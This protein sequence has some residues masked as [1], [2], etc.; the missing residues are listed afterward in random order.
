MYPKRNVFISY[1][2]G[3][4]QWYCDEFSRFFSEQ[5]DVFTDNSLERA[6]QSNDVDYV[7]W[8]IKQNNIKGSSCT[9]V[10][11][12]PDTWGRKYVDWEINATLDLQHGLVGILLPTTPIYPNGGT[13]K[14]KR[15]QD[16]IDSGYAEFLRWDACTVDNLRATIE[17]AVTKSTRL[18][19][20]TEPRRQRN[21]S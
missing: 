7:R 19:D 11:V 9:I 10:L 13:D 21:A 8:S 2:H 20:N 18:I 16:N 4:D 1:H 14:P 15:L 17:A 12:G 6:V 3:N 5:Y